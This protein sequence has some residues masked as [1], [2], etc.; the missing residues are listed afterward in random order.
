MTGNDE[1]LFYCIVPSSEKNELYFSVA[2]SCYTALLCN[3][4]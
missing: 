4:Q 3:D 2:I 1:K